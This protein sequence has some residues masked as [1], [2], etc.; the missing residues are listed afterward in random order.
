VSIPCAIVNGIRRETFFVATR[1][2]EV[3]HA[4]IR[5]LLSAISIMLTYRPPLLR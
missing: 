1:T 4:C 2:C 5:C 3:Y